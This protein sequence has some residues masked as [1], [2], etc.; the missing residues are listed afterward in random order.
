MN[1]KDE[2]NNSEKFIAFKSSKEKMSHVQKVKVK[3]KTKESESKGFQNKLGEF[4]SSCYSC[5]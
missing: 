2:K 1:K 4:V 5:L 3:Y